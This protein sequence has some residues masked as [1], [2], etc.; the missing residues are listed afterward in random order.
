MLCRQVGHRA[1]EFP[2]KAKPLHFHLASVHSLRTLGCAVFD[3][4][5]SGV[6]VKETKEDQDENDIEYFFWSHECS[7]SSGSTRRYRD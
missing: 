7:T 3:A 1:S 6:T 4:M 2:N 5:C